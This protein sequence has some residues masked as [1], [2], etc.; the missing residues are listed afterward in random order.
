MSIKDKLISNSLFLTLFSVSDALLFMVFWLILGKTL[1][2][3]SYGIVALSL[4]IVSFVSSVAIVGMAYTA[5]KLIP[6]YL[7]TGRKDEMQGLIYV[8]LAAAAMAAIVVSL[9]FLLVFVLA[10]GVIKLDSQAMLIT[11]VASVIVTLSV[12]AMN[13]QIG[14]QNMKRIFIVSIIGDSVLVAAVVASVY[15]GLGYIGP[16]IAYLIASSLVLALRLQKKFFSLSKKPV[17]DSHTILRYAVPSC[18]VCLLAVLASNTQYIILSAL[19]TPEV[20]GL[21]AVAMKI[22]FVLSVPPIVSRGLF[23]II[24]ELSVDAK[25]K[26]RQARLIS[27]TFRYEALMLLVMTALLLVF[28]RQLILF[29]A[30]PE[31]MQAIEV[32]PILVIANMFASFSDHF[33]T[34]LYAIGE[35]KKYRNANLVSTAAYLVLSVALTYYF[36]AVGL[37]VAFLVYNAMLFFISLAYTRASIP[38]RFPTVDIAKIVVATALSSAPLLLVV[39]TIPDVFVAIPFVIGSLV[40]NVL[41]LFVLRFFAEED[42]KVLDYGIERLPLFRKEALWIREHFAK[43][44]N[45][46]D[47]GRQC[48]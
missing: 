23:P 21:F 30:S 8:S 34:S 4:Q 15:F 35:P 10:P 20:I 18:V 3:A 2:P 40:L 14:F 26:P 33:T 42:L 11:A 37:A 1:E 38:F 22:G 5:N 28:G 44:V 13:K 41:I 43:L 19:K 31:Y 29:F 6:E 47:E 25:T 48:R 7:K 32:L 39:Q 12:I 45:A 9:G 36:S 17:V 24:S 27:L 46:R 16:I